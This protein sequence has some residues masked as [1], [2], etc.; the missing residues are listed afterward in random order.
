MG[1]KGFK[2]WPWHLNTKTGGGC[3]GAVLVTFNQAK[4]IHRTFGN[5]N[6]YY[7]CVVGSR[8]FVSLTFLQFWNFTI[9]IIIKLW[10]EKTK[11]KKENRNAFA[12]LGAYFLGLTLCLARPK[13]GRGVWRKS[14]GFGDK[15]ETWVY[16]L[17]ACLPNDRQVAQ[18]LS[19][20]PYGVQIK[21]L[22]GDDC[23]EVTSGQ[24]Y[25][26]E[27]YPWYNWQSFLVCICKII[28]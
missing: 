18:P 21:T 3:K 9:K 8:V 26:C 1:R 23:P 11:E 24:G 12:S 25:L 15:P 28:K 22:A 19:P 16:V 27:D 2:A 20:F 6:L 10:L 7:A 13:G 17:R 5:I 14:L 4:N